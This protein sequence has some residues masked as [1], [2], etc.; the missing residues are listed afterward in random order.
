MTRTHDVV[1][2]G[3]GVA[4]VCAAIQSA[5]LGANTALVE[6]ELVLG[7]NSNSSFCLHIEGASSNHKY[8]NE[9]GIIEELEAE[10]VVRGAFM[11]AGGGQPSY[12]NSRW[13]EI[14]L[15]AC[16]DSG[17]IVYLKTF[18]TRARTR[19]GRI[20]SIVAEDM[21]G[22]RQLGLRA[23]HVFIDASGDGQVAAAA[24]A[25]FRMGRE[26]RSEFGESFAPEIAD[27]RTMGNSLMFM[28]RNARRPIA[29]VPPPG[30]PVY[31]TDE[32]LPMGYHSAWDPSLDLPLIWTAEYGGHLDTIADGDEIYRGLLRM[33]HGIVDHLKHRG[34]HGAD[35]FELF[36][37]SPYM[38]KRESR[39]FVGDH[40]LSQRDLFEA[41]DFPDRVGYGGRA[42]DLHEVNEDGSKC[43]VHFYG[44]PP[45][46][47]IPLRCLYARNPANL[48]LAG[49]IISG[50][51]VALGSYRVMK[52]LATTGQ[53]VGAAAF[54]CKQHGAGPRRI[55]EDHIGELQQLLLREDATILNL[56]NDDPADLARTAAL[57][58]SS[59]TPDHPAAN[60]VD[61]VSRQFD[62]MPSHQWRSGEGLP[63]WIEVDFGGPRAV[64]MVQVTFDG[65]LGRTRNRHYPQTVSPLLARDYRLL[66]R[67]ASG[68][69]P[70]IAVE[71]NYQRFRRHCFRRRQVSAVRLEVLATHGANHARVY[72]LRAYGQCY[73]TFKTGQNRIVTP[74]VSTSC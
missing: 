20:T 21:L 29:Y 50:T 17:V 36:W 69:R 1:V 2:I 35:N 10:A 22:K 5:R 68:W 7:G 64:S 49:R 65:D 19:G 63:Q 44:T 41:P 11:P 72:E 13:S 46:Y 24:G 55:Y 73:V 39:R 33:V 61:G 3:G 38:G 51:R 62:E 14:L 57:R 67:A 4:G 31:E 43:R 59:A 25:E 58:A 12:F 47:S 23:R 60:L 30:T 15:Q 48:L 53:A 54:L 16:E 52:T 18:A 45:L 56:G 71:G 42:V 26:A 6:R 34:D 9:T 74:N 32:D 27:R 8:G 28:M 70:L 66:G 40:V 37:I